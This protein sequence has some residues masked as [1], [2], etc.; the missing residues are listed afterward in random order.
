MFDKIS[1]NESA[2]KL[3]R[4][5]LESRRVPGAL[6]FAGE[7]GV[8]KKLFALELAKALNCR[9][10]QGTE[11]CG[12]CPS[13]VRISKINFP[14]SVEPEELRKIFW[15]D[16][17][18][19]G[20][21]QPPG[22]VFHVAQKRAIE[23]EANFRPFEGAAR[24]FIVDDA[25]QLNDASANALLKV[26]EEPPPTSHLVLITSRPAMLLPTILSRCQAIRFSPLTSADIE[27]H[28]LDNKLAPAGDARLLARCAAGSMGRALSG[29][30]ESYKER[31]D[32]MFAV[33][34]ALVLTGDRRAL[35]RA[36]EGLNEARNRDDYE[37][38]LELLET[39]IRD[40]LLI[41][42]EAD[43]EQVV[44]E[45]LFPQLKEVA[46]GMNSHSAA[47]WIDQI[48]ELREQLVVNINRKPATDALLLT[49]AAFSAS[50][51]PPKRRFLIK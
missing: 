30:V 48:E 32:A 7:E 8:G 39:L 6:L 10:P 16:H 28:L 21:V 40:A 2:K 24:V 27:R 36:S 12:E 35:L 17:P 44:N 34:K 38:N 15:T 1:G 29:D 37:S 14:T 4:R 19:V 23:R 25:D 20:L 18:D 11:A 43:A 3:L 41:S 26:L 31:R 47:S 5:I 13:C 33:L 46:R 50:E 42:V 49:M 9:T 45:D 22:R 51:L